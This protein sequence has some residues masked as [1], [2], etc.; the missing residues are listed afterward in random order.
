MSPNSTSP[1]RWP[2]P[3][4][5][6]KPTSFAYKALGVLPHRLRARLP[7]GVLRQAVRPRLRHRSQ[8]EPG[9]RVPR[10]WTGSVTPPGST[11]ATRRSGSWNFGAKGPFEDFYHN[12]A[13]DTWANWAV[14]AGPAVRRPGTDSGHRDAHC[15]DRGSSSMYIMMW[16]VVLPPENHPFLDHHILGVITLIVLAGFHAGDHLG[17]GPGVEEHLARAEHPRAAVSTPSAVRGGGHLDPPRFRW[18]SS[19]RFHRTV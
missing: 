11:R 2:R 13:G 19:N 17:L 8:R 12:I 4:P 10:R 15:I 16:T 9:K 1:R 7:V 18:P 14:H 6:R 3:A 5:T